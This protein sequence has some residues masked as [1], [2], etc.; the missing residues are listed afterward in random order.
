MA[1]ASRQEHNGDGCW[2]RRRRRRRRGD[3]S[4]WDRRRLRTSPARRCYDRGALFVVCSWDVLVRVVWEKEGGGIFTKIHIQLCPA[5]EGLFAI[6]TLAVDL[7]MA[8]SH[9]GVMLNWNVHG[10]NNL[11]RRQVVRD[12]ITGHRCSLVCLQETTRS[13]AI[14]HFHQSMTS[15][16]FIKLNI[17]K[18]F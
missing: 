11:A 9:N 2:R 4:R 18:A 13:G 3:C 14:R 1:P 16:L 15:M 12:L 17:T 7:A 5:R 8:S 6:F 10:L